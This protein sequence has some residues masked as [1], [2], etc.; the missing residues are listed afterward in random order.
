MKQTRWAT[1]VC[2][3]IGACGGDV[4]PSGKA[5]GMWLRRDQQTHRSPIFRVEPF[6]FLRTRQWT[7]APIRWLVRTCQARGEEGNICASASHE[8]LKTARQ[9]KFHQKVEPVNTNETAVVRQARPWLAIMQRIFS[10]SRGCPAPSKALVDP[11]P[12]AMVPV[13]GRR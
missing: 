12:A 10:G 3:G 4:V 6:M 8:D 1:G 7:M 5:V 9:D 11:C 13:W 2:M